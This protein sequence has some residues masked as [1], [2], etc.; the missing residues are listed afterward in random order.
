MTAV[1]IAA[2]NVARQ[3]AD[4]GS[5]VGGTKNTGAE[6]TRKGWLSLSEIS[7]QKQG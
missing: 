7:A 1:I 5:E 2:G 3:G 4:V 6:K